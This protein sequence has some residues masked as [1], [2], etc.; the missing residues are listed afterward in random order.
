MEIKKYLPLF[1]FILLL[2]ITAI[3]WK[4]LIGPKLILLESQEGITSAEIKYDLFTDLINFF[5]ALIG[6]SAFAIYFWIQR[7]VDEKIKEEEKRI[8]SLLQC[9]QK[10]AWCVLDRARQKR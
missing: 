6:I 5:L 9:S 8:G 4:Y 1:Y 2:F 3:A 10:I 7:G